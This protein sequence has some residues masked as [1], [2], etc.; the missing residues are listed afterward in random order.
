MGTKKANESSHD[1]PSFG[2]RTSANSLKMKLTQ[3]TIDTIA[4][5]KDK[6]E[7][8]CLTRICPDSDCASAKVALADGYTNTKSA[9]AIGSMTLGVDGYPRPAP[10]SRPRYACQ[11]PFGLDPVRIKVK[12]ARKSG[13]ETLRNYL[14]HQRTHLKWRSYVEVER[15]LLKS[16][17][18]LHSSPLAKVDRR[19]VATLISASASNSGNVTA[20]RVRASLAAFFARAMR[21]GLVDTNPVIGTNRHQRS[22]EIAC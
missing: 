3:K 10:A 6:A 8:I 20:N 9:R 12:T 18:S 1:L 21:E 2:V 11:G 7:H 22:R 4:L 17:K 19:A 13:V 5:P 16:C 14:A 15:H